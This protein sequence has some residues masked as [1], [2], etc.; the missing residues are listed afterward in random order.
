MNLSEF[1][2]FEGNKKVKTVNQ[3]NIEAK[4]ILKIIQRKFKIPSKDIKVYSGVRFALL[5]NKDRAGYYAKL[6]ILLKKKFPDTMWDRTPSGLSSMGVLKVSNTTVLVKPKNLQASMSAGVQNEYRL[7]ESIN[8]IVGQSDTKQVD[9]LFEGKK[10]FSTKAKSFFKGI[11][12]AKQV[13]GGGLKSDINILTKGGKY[14]VSIKKLNAARWESSDTRF[15][16]VREKVL[17]DIEIGKLVTP[18]KAE[19]EWQNKFKT[20][21]RITPN[22]AFELPQK[23]WDSIIFGDANIIVAQTFTDK[24]FDYDAVT[25][26]LHIKCEYVFDRTFKGIKG[27]EKHPYVFIRNDS[28]RNPGHDYAGTRIEVVT[29]SRINKKVDVIPSSKI[30][31]YF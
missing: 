10:G 23:Y 18:K 31:K 28:T 29:K 26:I 21:C 4:E 17:R 7:T 2:F 12:E 3:L 30:N 27:T 9:I 19:V 5:V 14:G 25:N 15:G 16:L 20:L 24:D 6:E 8:Q 11:V 13:G 22:I 1:I